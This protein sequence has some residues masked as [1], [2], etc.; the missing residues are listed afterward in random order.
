MENMGGTRA[1]ASPVIARSLEELE[2]VARRDLAYTAYPAHPWVP[3]RVQDGEKLLDVAIIGAGQGGLA[4]AFGLLR[5][6]ITNIA[7]FDRNPEGLEGPW[8]TFARM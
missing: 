2:A 7:V 6:R 1:T 4:T 3:S 5:E 8:V